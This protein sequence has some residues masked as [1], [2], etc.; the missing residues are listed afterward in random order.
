MHWTAT[1]T[2]TW[3]DFKGK[4]DFSKRYLAIS[5]T[6]ISYSFHYSEKRFAYK[7]NAF[8]NRSR[9]WKKATAGYKVLKHEQGHFDITEIFARK[10]YEALQNYKFN[11]RSFKKDI[12]EIYQSIV[13]QKEEMQK[14]YDGET[15][16]SRN[17][18]LQYEWLEKIQG[19]LN[20]TAGY[21][22]YP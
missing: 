21:S 14:A 17:R 6:G 3:S 7:V 1:D 20:E 5:S 4:P 9:S 15:D 18:K 11:K 2:L 12:G 22:N 13:S 19:L 10:L 8:F 16:H